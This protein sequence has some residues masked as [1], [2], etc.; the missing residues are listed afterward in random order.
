LPSAYSP[1][2]TASAATPNF[3]HSPNAAPYAVVLLSFPRTGQAGVAELVSP[4]DQLQRFSGGEREVAE[5]VL[6]EERWLGVEAVERGRADQGIEG[7]GAL[8]GSISS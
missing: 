4:T 5:A 8:A 2:F 6:R 1:A 3:P 7:G